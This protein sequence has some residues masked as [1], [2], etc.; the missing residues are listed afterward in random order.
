MHYDIFC[1]TAM[2][3]R[4]IKFSHTKAEFTLFL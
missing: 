4:Y 2:I 3:E 1:T